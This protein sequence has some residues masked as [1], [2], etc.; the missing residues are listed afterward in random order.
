MTSPVD[1]DL[2]WW[3]ISVNV[4][5]VDEEEACEVEARIE[6]ALGAYVCIIEK[7]LDEEMNVN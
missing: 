3:T 1:A 2:E 6:A 5:V 7:Y 4:A